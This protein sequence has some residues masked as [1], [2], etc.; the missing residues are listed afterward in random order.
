MSLIFCVLCF[1]LLCY[2]L[3]L[4]LS[5]SASSFL[6]AFSL[7]SILPGLMGRTHRGIEVHEESSK[8]FDFPLTLTFFQLL[9]V[10]AALGVWDLAMH[11]LHVAPD[12]PVSQQR[13]W[14]CDA[15]F[16]SKAYDIFLICKLPSSHSLLCA[17]S[18]G[19]DC[20]LIFF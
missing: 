8:Q 14:I 20:V 4:F 9:G 12:R 5:S 18:L 11:S 13:S 15:R 19:F 7:P 2:F 10:A 1:C 16:F 6:I 17:S 3:A